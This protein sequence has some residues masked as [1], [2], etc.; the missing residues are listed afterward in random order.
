MVKRFPRPQR[1]L[2]TVAEVLHRRGKPRLSGRQVSGH[3]RSN[4]EH[5]E[6]LSY[7]PEDTV[8]TGSDS[9]C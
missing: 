4:H 6:L 8:Q 2:F 1:Q 5:D 7:V 9:G 3:S